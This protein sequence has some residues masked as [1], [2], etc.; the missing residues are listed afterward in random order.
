MHCNGTRRSI[1][2]S[3]ISPFLFNPLRSTR[4][5]ATDATRSVA[6]SGKLGRPGRR[7][8]SFKHVLIIYKRGQICPGSVLRAF[9]GGRR[10]S[11]PRAHVESFKI[12][13]IPLRACTRA[14]VRA[15]KNRR[16]SQLA[17]LRIIVCGV[18][19]SSSGQRLFAL[20]APWI[21]RKVSR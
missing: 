9:D 20:L 6:A 11:N 13:L 17:N 21:V 12:L 1:I 3:S 16:E 4:A 5:R 18:V 10:G 2:F 8:R 15:L 14:E 19:V 7:N